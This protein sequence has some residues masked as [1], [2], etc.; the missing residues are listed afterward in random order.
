MQGGG[1]KFNGKLSLFSFKTK[2]FRKIGLLQIKNRSR[3]VLPAKPTGWGAGYIGD[4]RNCDEAKRISHING[5]KGSE[6]AG[7]RVE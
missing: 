5:R 6:A 3:R 1:V 7:Y 4:R 2:C